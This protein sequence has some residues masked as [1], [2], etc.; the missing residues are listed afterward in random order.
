MPFLSPIQQ[1]Q[2][3]KGKLKHS[4]LVTKCNREIYTKCTVSEHGGKFW[5]ILYRISKL[6]ELLNTILTTM[7]SIVPFKFWY[8]YPFMQLYPGTLRW[9]PKLLIS[10]F[11]YCGGGDLIGGLHI[12]EFASP[13][14]LPSFLATSK[15]IMV[16]CSSSSLLRSSWNTGC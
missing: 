2:S 10:P 8:A 6:G 14:L 4:R 11:W 9:F 7:F 15:S 1:C 3:T 12:L 16:W 5:H 13:P